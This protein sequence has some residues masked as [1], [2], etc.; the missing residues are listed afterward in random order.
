[1][2]EPV[3]AETCACWPVLDAVRRDS[4]H[5]QYVDPRMC[6]SPQWS[7][8]I[9]Q[10]ANEFGAQHP[11]HDGC[12]MWTIIAHIG[13]MTVY[14]G[15]S[16]G[17]TLG[18]RDCICLTLVVLECPV[19]SAPERQVQRAQLFAAGI[20]A[21]DRLVQSASLFSVVCSALGHDTMGGLFPR[22]KRKMRF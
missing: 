17:R 6:Y 2:W 20:N 12:L 11:E 1:M 15:F 7:H 16:R 9:C 18:R 8:W 10:A 5:V 3:T 19:S 14:F 21:I 22:E 13:I 4:P